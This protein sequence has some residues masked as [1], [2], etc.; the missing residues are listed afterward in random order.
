M[1]DLPGVRDTEGAFGWI[2]GLL[3]SGGFPWQVVGGLAAQIYGSPRPLA[4]I[5][6]DTSH[7]ALSSVAEQAR[8]YLTFGPERYRD[9]EFDIEL[10]SLRWRGQDIDLTAAEDI[11]LFDRSGRVWREVPTDLRLYESHHVYGRRAQVITRA[12]LIEYKRIIDRPVDRVDIEAIE[13]G[14]SKNRR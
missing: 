2:T 5:D 7:A 6:I 9:S 4:D 8:S 14:T 13:R 11:R 3:D 12:G 1:T 10:L